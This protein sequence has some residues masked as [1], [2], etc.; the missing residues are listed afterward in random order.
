MKTMSMTAQRLNTA[1][2]AL[3]L[4]AGNAMGQAADPAPAGAD[5]KAGP[6]WSFRASAYGYF[7]PDDRK[8]VQPSFSADRERLHLEARYNYED[9][10]TG[11]LWAGAN[12][13]AG[14]KLKLD[15]TP[16]VG[17]VFG[18]TAGIS[19]GYKLSLGCGKVEFYSEGEYVFDL[20]DRQGNFFYAWS[21]LSYSPVEWMRA[22][23]VGQRTRAYQTELDIQRGFLVGFSGRKIDFTAHVFNLGWTDPT[24]ILAIG[25]EF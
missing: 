2:M 6:K 20:R 13:G 19:P 4:L 5:A 3:A 22:G 12:F 24:V 9:K 17:G 11:S 23:I 8:Y 15:V 14:D 25:V 7:I 1:V 18:N 16:M 21:E 10:E